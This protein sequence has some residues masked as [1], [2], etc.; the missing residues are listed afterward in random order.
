MDNGRTRT[1]GVS[2]RSGVGGAEG[3]DGEGWA[4]R[5]A[6]R[7]DV[8]EAD[9]FFAEGVRCGGGG[10][11]QFSR[12]GFSFTTAFGRAEAHSPEHRY[13]AGLRDVYSR[14]VFAW[15]GFNF[16]HQIRHCVLHKLSTKVGQDVLFGVFESRFQ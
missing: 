2:G 7:S 13:S 10:E 14:D 12:F 5:E 11:M 16:G 3:G 15:A 8:F 6:V 9:G 4:V 1:G